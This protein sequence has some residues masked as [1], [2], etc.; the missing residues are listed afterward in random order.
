MKTAKKSKKPINLLNVFTDYVS[1][2]DL[3]M[4]N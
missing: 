3:F 2:Y 4:P 1:I